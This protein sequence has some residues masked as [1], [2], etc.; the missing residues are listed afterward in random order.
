MIRGTLSGSSVHASL[1]ITPG[2][3][4]AF[5]RRPSAGGTS[6]HTSGGSGSAPVWLKLER[7]GPVITAFR[8]TDGTT[9]TEIGSQTLSLP[10]SFYVGLAVTSHTAWSAATATFTNVAVDTPSST[11]N[12]APSVSL[13]APTSGATFTAPA[14][15]GMA[16]N[17][18]DAD[19]S[20][21]RVDFY[22][23]STLVASDTT[24]PFSASWSNVAAG[25]Y[26]LTAKATDD[27]GSSTTSAARSVT[28]SAASTVSTS[29]PP[30]PTIPGRAVFTPST[31]HSTL[32]RYQLEI[33]LAGTSPLIASPVATRDLGKP[34][35]VN[36][37]CSV[38][39]SQTVLAL[40]PGS[41]V[42]TVTAVSST[43]STR[44]ALSPVFTR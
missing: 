13:T 4:V 15:F 10:S 39:I 5:Q 21:S 2:Q 27:D 42:A 9:W 38:D 18:T 30:P 44:S 8:S 25:T 37:E 26:S 22:A 35:I 28:V 36:G 12:Q 6:L 24:S 41:Y 11:T 1:F 29:L 23:N 19:G 14:T 40:L 3:G 20:I 17:A 31:D 33:F 32:Q 43:G 34:A 7:R 16:A